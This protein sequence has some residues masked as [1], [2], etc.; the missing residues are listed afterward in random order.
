MCGMNDAEYI[1]LMVVA[2]A[3]AGSEML[4]RELEETGLAGTKDS[5][6]MAV[7][8]TVTKPPEGAAGWM[9]MKLGSKP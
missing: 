1:R 4:R 7:M 9:K 8:L 5:G 2:S 3:S 6:T